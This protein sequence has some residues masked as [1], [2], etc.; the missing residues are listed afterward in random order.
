MRYGKEMKLSFQVIRM[1]ISCTP[2]FTVFENQ[3]SHIAQK[4]NFSIKETAIWSHLLKKSLME[5]FL[6]SVTN[7]SIFLTEMTIFI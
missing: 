4:M 5:N 3:V 1:R 2:S 7:S 6:R